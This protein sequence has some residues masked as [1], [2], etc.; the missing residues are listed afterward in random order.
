MAFA[1]P[2]AKAREKV[3]AIVRTAFSS[4]A[5]SVSGAVGAA[6]RLV[7]ACCARA[8]AG[9]LSHAHASAIAT[10]IIG[11]L[12]VFMMGNPLLNSSHNP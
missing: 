4:S 2:A 10:D 12:I 11:L 5:R 8:V 1:S 3:S 7:F 6:A 9:R